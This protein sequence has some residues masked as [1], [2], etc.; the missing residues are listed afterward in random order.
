[1]ARLSRDAHTP[2]PVLYKVRYCRKLAN[3]FYDVG[4][5][6]QRVLPD[7]SGEVIALGKKR[8]HKKADTPKATANAADAT[9]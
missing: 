3:D 6:F 1:M 7:S 8:G 9:D 4:V 2:V 5:M